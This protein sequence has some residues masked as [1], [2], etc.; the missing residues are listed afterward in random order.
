MGYPTMTRRG[1]GADAVDRLALAVWA[2]QHIG[3]R[4]P[5]AA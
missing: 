5:I 2:T 1:S 3:L 4:R